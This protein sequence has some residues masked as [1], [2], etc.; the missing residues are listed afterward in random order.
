[1]KASELMQ[2]LTAAGAPMEAVLIAVRA[3]EAKQDEIDAIEA[4]RAEKRAKDAARKKAERDA[5]RNVHGQSMDESGTVQAEPSLSPSPLSSPQTPQHTPR[6]HTHPDNTPRARKADPFPCPDWCNPA[7]WN[8]L[9]RNR[10]TKKLTDTE[11]AHRRFCADV[12]AMAD[13][14]WPPGRLVEAIAAK[15]WGGAHDPRDDRKPGK[16][17][18]DNAIRTLG[19]QGG[20]RSNLAKAI[21]EGLD[22]LG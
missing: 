11:T 13:D 16:P 10:K 22:W 9:K 18:N 4:Q 15:G 12:L 5:A 3:L 19:S 20:N 6:P 2:A 21:D 8:D 7:V 1:M 14:E 17:N